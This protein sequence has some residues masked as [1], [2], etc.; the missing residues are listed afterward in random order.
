[1]TTYS[2]IVNIRRNPNQPNS[3]DTVT[4]IANPRPP[5]GRA[6]YDSS[7]VNNAVTAS[8]NNN[9]N[10]NIA[11]IHPITPPRRLPDIQR[12]AT[13]GN[14]PRAPP[15]GHIPRTLTTPNSSKP[16]TASTERTANPV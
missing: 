5:R 9:K 8:Y 14:R 11:S 13:T 6:I 4:D 3:R 16:S 10:H 15:F 7:V 2:Y 1:M 12:P